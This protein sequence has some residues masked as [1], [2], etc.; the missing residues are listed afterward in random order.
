MRSPAVV[1]LQKPTI[2]GSTGA[3][4]AG[5]IWVL[6]AT[7]VAHPVE[8]GAAKNPATVGS[9]A[10]ALPAPMP[11]QMPDTFPR[12][13]GEYV[14]SKQNPRVFETQADLN[15]IAKR[16]NVSGSYSAQNFARLT[17]SAKAHLAS[18]M[19]WDAT[20]SGC[21]IY[22]YLHV[23]SIES[24]S[25]YAGETASSEDIISALKVRPGA[26]PPAGVAV[27][28]AQFA[29]YAALVKAGVTVPTGA[30]SA[31]QATAVAKRI[32]LAWADHGFRDA[33]G[34]FRQSTA[35][36]CKSDGKPAEP[37]ANA[38]Q[39]ARGV[40]YSV[41]A[42]DLLQGIGAFSP[43]EVRRL[44]RF[45]EG[46]Y[47]TIRTV[48]NEEFSHSIGTK[49]G[50]ETY[51][52]QFATHLTA[53]IAI[54]RLLDDR[55]TLQAALYGGDPAVKVELP[56][57]KLF[58]YIIYG[59]NDRP[60]TRVSPNSS[61]DPVK[62]RPAYT[63]KL[64]AP[65]EIND[66]FRNAHEMAGIGYPMFSL[67][68]LYST[69]ETLRISGY[70]P[71]AYHGA[72][73]Q[74]IEMTTDYYACFGTQPGFKNTVTADN[75]RACQDYQQYIGKVVVGVENAAVIGA[76]RFP[77][78]AALTQVEAAAKAAMLHDAIDTAL[79]GRWRD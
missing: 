52:N 61:N 4:A 73:Q 35:Q 22:I 48:S 78:D 51:N 40:M 17:T 57:T 3:L 2:P 70:N 39:I 16:T 38:L 37:V 67:S 26:A 14:S 33:S 79:Y 25:G 27:L 63:T 71:Y 7:Q 77:A 42:Q 66:R 56:W 44:N 68:T 5:V 30:P 20:Y 10:M 50:D 12:L 53:L 43:D 24:E 21:N 49:T 19:D 75:A 59:V 41:Q 15:D 62:S 45:H 76:Y 13:A 54:A 28:A 31:D 6:L 72:H 23:F 11:R 36:Y 69:A 65:G 64:V 58:S 9:G 29:L 60:L 46:M 18:K 47:K 32:L 1:T 74:T 34:N 55:R 8:A